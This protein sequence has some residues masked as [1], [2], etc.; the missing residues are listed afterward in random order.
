VGIAAAAAAILGG[1]AIAGSLTLGG[2]FTAMLVAYLVV[3]ALYSAA[4]KHLVILDVMAISLGFVLRVEAGAAAI[5][6]AVSTWLLLCTIFVS[7]FLA[8]SKRRHEIEF[9]QG[10]AGSREVLADYSPAFLDQMINVVTASTLISYALYAVSVDTV[11]NFGSTDLI[12]TLPLVLY[13]IFRY[14]FLVY[15]AKD[16]HSPTE[17]VLRDPPSLIN[18]FLWVAMVLAIIYRPWG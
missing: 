6:V 16:P 7:L 9:V 1:G 4:L 18:G 13:G 3:N 12:Y 11:E 15:Q 17:A 8:V 2:R 14:L 5:G 10:P